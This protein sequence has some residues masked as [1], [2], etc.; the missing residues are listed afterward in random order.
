MTTVSAT[1]LCE[2]IAN[3]LNS[4]PPAD[5]ITFVAERANLKNVTAKDVVTPRCFIAPVGIEQVFSTRSSVSTRYIVGLTLCQM[6]QST[7]ISEEDGLINLSESLPK[8]LVDF[9][10]NHVALDTIDDDTTRVLFGAEELAAGSVFVARITL[11]FR[12][13]G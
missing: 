1:R 12:N 2:E 4:S 13:E 7:A 6:L 8:L 10:W 3:Y 5:Q 9:I 11:A